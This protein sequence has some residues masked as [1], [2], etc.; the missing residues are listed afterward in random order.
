MGKALLC[1]GLLVPGL[2]RAEPVPPPAAR[3]A[4]VEDLLLRTHRWDQEALLRYALVSAFLANLDTLL[5]PSSQGERQRIDH[6]ARRSFAEQDFKAELAQTLAQELDDATM[7][8]VNAWFSTVAGSEVVMWQA[9]MAREGTSADRQAALARSPAPRRGL[10]ARAAAVEGMAPIVGD[11]LVM[12]MMALQ[13]AVAWPDEA[14]RLLALGRRPMLAVYLREVAGRWLTE[15]DEANA[16]FVL[17]RVDEP[18]LRQYVDFL[19]SPAGRR[20]HRVQREALAQ[21]S[22][23]A[24]ARC[25]ARLT[26]TADKARL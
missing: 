14:T 3:V 4:A 26:E 9:T 13:D 12:M 22:Y 6:L 23:E 25:L 16:A 20:Y 2:V 15:S 10:Y 18:T 8:T 11:A 19:E 5:P 7:D 24:A 21:S 1:L 17:E